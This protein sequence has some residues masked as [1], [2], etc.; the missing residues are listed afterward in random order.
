VV[1]RGAVAAGIAEPAGLEDTEG[2]GSSWHAVSNCIGAA[3]AALA[4]VACALQ[5]LV[6]RGTQG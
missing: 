6:L 2:R 5:V 1:R 4:I 3:V